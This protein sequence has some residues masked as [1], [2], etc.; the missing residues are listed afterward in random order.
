MKRQQ[1]KF[2]RPMDQNDDSS[3]KT[4]SWARLAIV[5]G[6]VVAAAVAW[7]VPAIAP[8]MA[9]GLAA[10]GL[11]LVLRR[12]EPVTRPIARKKQT[13]GIQANRPLVDAYPDP[14][15]IFDG[16]G[17][18]IMANKGAQSVF[19][20]LTAGTDVRLVLRT[21]EMVALVSQALQSGAA[22][23]NDV[24]FRLPVEHVF[25]VRMETIAGEPP[26]LMAVF[27]DRSEMRRLDRMRSDFIA[28]ASHELR[29]P[30]ASISGFI[31][32]LEGPASGDKAASAR[33]LGIMKVQAN[34][35]ARLID[36]LLSLSRLEMKASARRDFPVDL[37]AQCETV[38]SALSQLA[39]DSNVTIERDWQHADWRVAGE[40]DELFQVLENLVANACKYG[41]EGGRVIIRL[42]KAALAGRPA[43]KV[44]VQDFGRGIAKEH[45]PRLTERFYRGDSDQ[46]KVQ[47][48]TGLGLAIVKHIITLHKGRLMIDSEVG[49]GSTFSVLLPSHESSIISGVGLN[50][51]QAG[52]TDA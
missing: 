7:V 41:S 9:A 51:D 29:T 4:V 20:R 42:E 11:I 16:R 38:I 10:A 37:V 13:A 30:L 48:G 18:I 8:L 22:H 35:M 33:F 50:R 26:V 19:G 21:P 47:K 3:A 27:S 31:E 25:N 12:D 23:A 34:R 17:D 28:N 45:V 2:D 49:K 32:T 46:A 44:S 6:L 15:I 24:A 14:V 40:S 43:V 39:E 1:N 5:A 52:Q 36:D